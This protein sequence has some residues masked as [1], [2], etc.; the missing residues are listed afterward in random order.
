MNTPASIPAVHMECKKGGPFPGFLIHLES[1]DRKP[2]IL[3][4]IGRKDG[5]GLVEKG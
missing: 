5:G 2:S 3:S 4:S 1:I